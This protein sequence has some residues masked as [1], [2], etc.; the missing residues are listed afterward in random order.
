MSFSIDPRLSRLIA[1]QFPAAKTAGSFF[2]LPGLTGMSGKVELEG[3]TLLARYQSQQE[4]IPGVDRRREYHI[5]RKLDGTGLA[6]EVHGYADNWLLLSWQAGERLSDAGF[7]QALESVTECVASLHRQKLSGYRLS[8]LSLLEQY[9]QLSRP[10]RRHCGWLRA[11]RWLQK[12]GEPRP[13]RLSLLH[14]DVH[15]GNIIRG[16]NGLKL[17]DWEYASDG[18]VALEL[19]AIAL[20]N[21]LSDAQQQEMTEHYAS[22]QRLDVMKLQRQMLRWQPWLNLLVACWYEL[23]WQKSHEELFY[24]LAEQAWQRVLSD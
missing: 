13:L 16:S 22:L 7:L 24:P 9:W 5:L 19:A 23:R 21:Q 8:V 2:P 15:A 18:D 6:P 3:T 12:H 11:L 20:S 10:A 14:M 4:P 1:Q 17:I